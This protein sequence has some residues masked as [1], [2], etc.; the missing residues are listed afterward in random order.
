[1]GTP[2]ISSGWQRWQ[3]E[4]LMLGVS[5]EL[6]AER[7]LANGFDRDVARA[8][9]H[10]E[11]VDPYLVAGRW[12][13]QRLKKLESILEITYQLQNLAPGSDSV[14]RRSELSRDEFVADF[15]ARNRPVVIEDLA[16]EWPALAL[17]TP[18][19]LRARLGDVQVE[20]MAGRTNDPY[21][22]LNL[23]AHRRRLPFSEYVDLVLASPMTNDLYMVANNHL[24]EGPAGDLLWPDISLDPRYL[25]P[26]RRPEFTFFWFGPAGTITPLHHD[27]YNILF[28]QVLGRKRFTLISPLLT[29]R[30][31]NDLGVYTDLDPTRPDL[32]RFPHYEGTVPLTLELG[33]GESLFIPV[34]WWHRVESLDVSVS[35][36]LG[37]FSLPNSFN[38]S[39]PAIRPER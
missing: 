2:Y 3:A 22:E 39:H 31:G 5:E 1:M 19:M 23:D 25:E 28:V 16:S 21:Y 24:F 12:M 36:S 10:P 15:Y 6:M 38:W 20:I 11:S 35:V 14:P 9:L 33:P 32:T 7:M 27:Q 13:V 4:N 30:L 29:H 17:W 18:G 8:N 26:T 34:G 37:S